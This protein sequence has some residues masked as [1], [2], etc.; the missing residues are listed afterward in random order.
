VQSV[1]IGWRIVQAMIELAGPAILKIVAER[2]GMSSPKA[3]RYLVSYCRAG[4]AVQDPLSGAYRLGPAA[5]QLGLTALHRLDVVEVIAPELA[6]LR[7]RLQCTVGLSV[8]GNL[9]PT[10]VHVAECSDVTL[11]TVRTGTVMPVLSS[12]SG[13]VYGAYMSP[14]AIK[15]FIQTERATARLSP[16]SGVNRVLPTKQAIEALFEQVRRNG[17]AH[18]KGEM[19]I[20]VHAVAVPVFDHSGNI[21]ASLAALGAAGSFDAEFDGTVAQELMRSARQFSSQLG[22]PAPSD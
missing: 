7:D 16:A 22:Y 8:W 5:I 21:T 6:G 10:F 14:H 2:A 3:L 17:A 15:P 1:E 12:A 4:V 9:G 13:R 18:V 19:N 11:I 20:G